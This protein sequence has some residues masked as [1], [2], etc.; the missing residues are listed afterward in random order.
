MKTATLTPTQTAIA[1]QLASIITT[2]GD[3]AS[4]SSIF[5]STCYRVCVGF[6]LIGA[7]KKKF[8]MLCGLPH[9]LCS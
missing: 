6:N 2:Y 7:K 4:D 8:L 1:L 5:F 9:N 3:D